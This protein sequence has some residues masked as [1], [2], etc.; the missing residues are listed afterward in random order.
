[1]SMTLAHRKKNVPAVGGRNEEI[2]CELLGID[3]RES[4][5]APGKN[6]GGVANSSMKKAINTRRKPAKK[7]PKRNRCI[8][9]TATDFMELFVH[10]FRRRLSSCLYYR[11]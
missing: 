9:K 3:T 10:E 7:L 4:A 5:E 6:A 1:M 2:Y 11:G 8:S